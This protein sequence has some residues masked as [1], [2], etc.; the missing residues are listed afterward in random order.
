MEENEFLVEPYFDAVLVK[1]I[2]SEETM[3]GAII[4]PDAGKEKNEKGTVVA[5]GP[6]FHT[7]T[8]TFVPTTAKVGEVVILPT[9]GFTKFEFGG[10]E[11][12]IGSE[13]QLLARIKQL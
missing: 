4:V 13:K 12:L 8:G 6:G 9:M 7:V 2:D 3:Y 10:D 1:I 5:V 11:Y